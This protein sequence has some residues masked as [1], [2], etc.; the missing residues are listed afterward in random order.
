MTLSENARPLLTVLVLAVILLSCDIAQQPD[1]AC[2]VVRGT[3]DSA[4]A[5]IVWGG[6]PAKVT[7][8]IA[9][10]AVECI[11][12]FQP[13]IDTP[14]ARR[15]AYN[16]YQIAVTATVNY[17]IKD[18]AY[19]DRP[20]DTEANIIFE[21]VSQSGVVLGSARSRFRI[22]ENV[23]AGTASARIA[24]LTDSEIRKVVAV[25]AKWEYETSH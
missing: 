21:A 24:S 2:P 9:S 4:E 8:Q 10:V 17:Q 11:P 19:V 25:R 3:P 5:G 14:K 12:I 13:A 7:A 22:I 18:K 6:E 23:S 15:G 1:N 20:P 16:E